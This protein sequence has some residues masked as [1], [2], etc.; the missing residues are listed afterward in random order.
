MNPLFN[1]WLK[2]FNSPLFSSPFY[3][4]LSGDVTQDI[5]PVTSWLSPQF[6]FNFAGNKNVEKD[7]VSN[8]ASYGR[9]LGV[10]ANAL[11]EIAEKTD[12]QDGDAVKRL[13]DMKARI[14]KVK[15]RHSGNLE[16]R[17]KQ[18]LE[19]LKEKDKE[20]FEALLKSYGI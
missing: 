9:Q 3:A 12:T 17:I 19:T 15:C 20:K 4:P 2:L 14:D 8:V 5:S 6:E 13:K 7:V 10:I 1:E 18:D 11:L 16:E